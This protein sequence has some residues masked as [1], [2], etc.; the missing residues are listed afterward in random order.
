MTRG[1]HSRWVVPGEHRASPEYIEAGAKIAFGP[2]VYDRRNELGFSQAELARRA[3]MT[4]PAVSRIE[5]GGVT[6]TLPLL[7]RL[8]V[9]LQATLDVSMDGEETR[10]T[11]AAEA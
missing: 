6:P 1:Y 7:R 3:D 5:G 10:V 11:L 8:A 4:Q 2:A 9:A